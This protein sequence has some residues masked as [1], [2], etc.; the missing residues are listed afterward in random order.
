MHIEEVHSQPRNALLT[1]ALAYPEAWEDHPWGE[2]VAKVGKK[3]FFTISFHKEML[4]I[5]CKLPESN[6]SAVTLPFA[7]PAGYGL[8]NS[9]WVTFSFSAEDEIPVELLLDWMDE[10]Y[11]AIAPKK[12]VKLLDEAGRP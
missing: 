11:R 3:L 8:G 10:S 6:G 7:A 1:A 12:L 9:G 2:S 4:Y 5:T